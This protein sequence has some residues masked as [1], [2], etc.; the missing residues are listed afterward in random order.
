MGISLVLSLIGFLL[1]VQILSHVFGK[2]EESVKTNAGTY[3]FF[4]LMSFP[5]I[6]LYNAASALFRAQGNSRV[7]MYT[8]LFVNILNIGGN[9]FCIYY[10]RMGVEGVAIP[11]LISRGAAAILL[12]SL[13][14]RAKPYYGKPAINIKGLLKIQPDF[15]TIKH[16]LGIGVPN[17]IENSVFQVGKILTLAI[18]TMFGTSAIAANAAA[19][20]LCGFSAIPGTAVS[21]ASLTVVGQCLGADKPNEAAY[22]TKKL[23]VMAYVS[24]LVLNVP[25]TLASE[26]LIS[27]F[28][29]SEE[30]SILAKNMIVLHNICCVIIW[31]L[32]WSLPNALRAANDARFTMIVSLIC[33]WFVRI[34]LCYAFAYLTGWGAMGVWYAM[35]ADWFVRAII[36]TTRFAHGRWRLHYQLTD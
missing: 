19:I 27:L 29:L 17:G 6:A 10:L 2:I 21:L 25:L 26:W 23:L 28:N 5:L 24:I 12:L 14:Y 9:A 13:L 8:A 1:R 33:V 35:I 22:F 11:T 30:A 20:A 34:G 7:S 18:I 32:S 16:I 31:P 4:M 3:L 15:R 36:F